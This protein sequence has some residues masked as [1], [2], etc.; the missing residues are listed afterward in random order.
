MI[1]IDNILVSDAVVQDYFTCNLNAC[2]G[3]CCV[4]GESGAPLE[5]EELE[6]L[7]KIYPQ[8]KPYLTEEGIQI[9]EAK[10]FFAEEKKGEYK[11]PL[12]KDGACVYIRYENKMAQCGIQKAYREGKVDFEKPISCHLYPIRITKSKSGMTHVNY[13]EWEICSPACELGKSLKMPLYKFVK[14]ALV[15]KFGEEFYVTL[16]LAAAQL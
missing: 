4:E 3:A 12:M 6:T 8:V 7:E 13:D 14:E 11:T 9:I 1:A 15:R 10:G 5:P 16:D 2:K